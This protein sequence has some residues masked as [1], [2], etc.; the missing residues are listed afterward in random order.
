MNGQLGGAL[1]AAAAAGAVEVAE[2]LLD[3]LADPQQLDAQGWTALRVAQFA[4]GVDAARVGSIDDINRA[5]HHQQPDAQPNPRHQHQQLQ[6]RQAC[7]S[8][9]EL[10]APNHTV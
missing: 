4:A 10:L 6:R 3:A 9:V 1:H 7:L 5:E 8:V 2:L